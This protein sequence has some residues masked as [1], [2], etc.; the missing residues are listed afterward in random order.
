MRDATTSHFG[1]LDSY[2][3]D[4]A[5]AGT[6]SADEERELARRLHAGDRKAGD[7]LVRVNLP[8]VITIARE[9]RRW[10]VPLEDLVQQG[11]LGLLKAV[12]RFDPE[13]QC[14]LVT[15]AAYWVR[16]EMPP[17]IRR[18]RLSHGSSRHDQGRAPRP[19]RLPQDR[20]GRPRPAR[21]AVRSQAGKRGTAAS[22]CCPRATSRST[23]CTALAGPSWIV[24]LRPNRPPRTP[25]AQGTATRRRAGS[26]SKAL[27]GMDP[28]DRAILRARLLQETPV[29]LESLG[30]RFGISKER[31]RQL[32]ER[33]KGQVRTRLSKPC[34]NSPR[35]AEPDASYPRSFGGGRSCVRFDGRAA[36]RYFLPRDG[37]PTSSFFALLPACSLAGRER[38]PSAAS[39][40]TPTEPLSRRT[41]R[42]GFVACGIGQQ[43]ND[44]GELRHPEQTMV[45]SQ[46]SQSQRSETV[47]VFD[48]TLRDG[49][50]SAGVCFSIQDKLDIAPRSPTCASTSSRWA[51]PLPRRS[52]T[53]R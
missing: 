46:P 16:A 9:Y 42:G 4:I 52:S 5:G 11:N 20:R 33:I 21:G 48:T 53:R 47:V 7:R 26:F 39:Q 19:A 23:R 31:V 40:K 8:F 1:A 51:I 24:F 41:R 28:R 49:E 2:R 18:A 3:R 15:Y 36:I 22:R 17:R 6:L 25:R 30:Q 32:E 14:R 13:R 44:L 50:Q 43:G 45:P 34:R 10:G 27:R 29:T 12:A 37:A 35:R 38:D